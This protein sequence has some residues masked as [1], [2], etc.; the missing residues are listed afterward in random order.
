[1]NVSCLEKCLNLVPPSY[2]LQAQQ[3][4]TS[5]NQILKNLLEKVCYCI[6]TL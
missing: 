2:I 6:G 3:A 5:R 1:M 4:W